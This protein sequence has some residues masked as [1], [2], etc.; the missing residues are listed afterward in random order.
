MCRAQLHNLKRKRKRKSSCLQERRCWRKTQARTPKPAG[1]I[2]PRGRAGRTGGG[3]AASSPGTRCEADPSVLD[4]PRGLRVPSSPGGA[5]AP[6]RPRSARRGAPGPPCASPGTPARRS[7]ARRPPCCAAHTPRDGPQLS[8]HSFPPAQAAPHQ[9]ALRAP[10]ASVGLTSGAS[11]IRHQHAPRGR[12]MAAASGSRASPLGP[13]PGSR[14]RSPRERRVWPG[15]AGAELGA[16][17]GGERLACGQGRWRPGV[18]RGVG[19][20]PGLAW[21]GAGPTQRARS[22][23]L[24]RNRLLGA[25]PAASPRPC[26]PGAV[27]P[28]L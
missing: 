16:E 15:G 27:P 19:G 10:P 9:R 7:P 28:C 25:L 14:L 24:R 3:G 2:R 23:G 20:R 18:R 6:R 13:Q 17:A 22:S 12:P 8:A 21:D 11:L 26:S 1:R 5:G 4:G